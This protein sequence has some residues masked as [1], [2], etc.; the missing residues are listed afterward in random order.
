M[1]LILF[2][3]Y[4][5]YCVCFVVLSVGSIVFR[6]LFSMLNLFVPPFEL[7]LEKKIIFFFGG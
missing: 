7:S 5:L 2:C 3:E 1:G 4:V 6:I